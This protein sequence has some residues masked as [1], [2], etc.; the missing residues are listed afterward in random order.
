[1]LSHFQ[2]PLVY[3]LLAAVV[4]AFVA[5][6]IEC[7][8]GWPL[9]GIVILTI[10]LLNG[11]QKWPHLFKQKFPGLKWDLAHNGFAPFPMLPFAWLAGA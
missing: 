9:D 2:D 8:V 5:W 1:M 3:L 10:V 6:V 7:L 4:I 11:T